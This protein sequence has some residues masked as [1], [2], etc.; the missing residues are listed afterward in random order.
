VILNYSHIT[1]IKHI[2]E[3]S[4]Q[5]TDMGCKAIHSIEHKNDAIQPA[6]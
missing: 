3:G 6:S 2:I 1:N 4:Q 5:S